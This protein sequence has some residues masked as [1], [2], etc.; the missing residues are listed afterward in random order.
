MPSTLRGSLLAAVQLLLVAVGGGASLLLLYTLLTL[1]PAPPGSDGFVTGGA[2]LWGGTALVFTLGV[3]GAGVVLPTVLGGD[4]LLGLGR[5]QRTVLKAAAACF[6]GGLLLGV[7]LTA[8]VDFLFGVLALFLAVLLGLLLVA[9]VLA[10]RLSE[11][12]LERQGRNAAH[13]D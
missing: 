7:G 8:A 3:T 6:G 10:W 9:L 12:V 13:I 5:Y 2:Y 4:E 11:V 1:P